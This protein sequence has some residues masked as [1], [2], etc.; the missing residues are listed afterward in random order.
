VGAKKIATKYSLKGL[1]GILL[2]LPILLAVCWSART[3][4]QAVVAAIS[5]RFQDV[6]ELQQAQSDSPLE[7]RRL[8][9]KRFLKYGVYIPMEDITVVGR[10]TQDEE[11]YV[12]FMR[13][14]CGPGNIFIWVPLRFHWPVWGE[15]VIEWCWKPNIAKQE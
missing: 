13:K 9:Q 2:A 11:K 14:A 4:I 6:A 7:L 15:Q 12:F 3:A 1:R 5:V 8:L 10:D